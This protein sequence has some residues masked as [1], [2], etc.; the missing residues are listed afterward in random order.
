[1]ITFLGKL[2]RGRERVLINPKSYSVT[3]SPQRTVTALRTI[4]P[5]FSLNHVALLILIYYFFFSTFFFLVSVLVL[6]VVFFTT[7]PACPESD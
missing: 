2:E 4:K 1:M 6:A 5:R 3:V 7:C